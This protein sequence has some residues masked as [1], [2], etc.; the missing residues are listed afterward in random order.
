M[1]QKIFKAFMLIVGFIIGQSVVAQETDYRSVCYLKCNHK[2]H[3]IV[4]STI[5]V[6]GKPNT[7]TSVINSHNDCILESI[8]FPISV[9]KI[10]RSFRGCLNLKSVT[11]PNKLQRIYESFY[12]CPK[13]TSI[14]LPDA[15][16]EIDDCFYDCSLAT[17]HLPRNLEIL[18]SSF[19]RCYKLTSIKIPN[20]LKKLEGSFNKCRIESITFEG[21]FDNLKVIDDCFKYI[22]T[23]NDISIPDGVEKISSSFDFF[24]ANRVILPRSI[25]LIRKSFR[26]FVI[27]EL[28]IHNPTPPNVEGCEM[29]NDYSR[30]NAVL[31][32]PKGSLNAYKKANGFKNFKTIK[33]LE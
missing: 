3:I 15:L 19:E 25:K 28:I 23:H 18:N 10:E 16:T 33:E 21:T 7:V 4:P 14:T 17:V 2:G 1:K 20:S 26:R 22:I 29:E 9:R 31:Y 32:V 24:E 5:N 6:L 12:N 8:E 30:T 13:L 27:N 11:F